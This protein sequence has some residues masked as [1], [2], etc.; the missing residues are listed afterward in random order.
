[1]NVPRATIGSEDIFW[2]L[3]LDPIHAYRIVGEI[4][5]F[6]CRISISAQGKWFLRKPIGIRW[7]K[8]RERVPQDG[9]FHR[10]RSPE[11]HQIKW[12]C[13]PPLNKWFYSVIGS[14][15]Q[16]SILSG[17]QTVGS[18]SCFGRWEV[19]DFLSSFHFQSFCLNHSYMDL[20]GTKSSE[21]VSIPAVAL[22][23][24][25]LRMA[26]F[27][28]MPIGRYGKWTETLDPLRNAFYN[29]TR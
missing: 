7:M 3:W 20:S 17:I 28:R 10:D 29:G 9:Q 14:P 5:V 18:R 12:E 23:I 22:R 21:N 2:C 24:L 27:R 25:V 13:V 11:W 8:D 1:M 4:N 26:T 6:E 16:N 15:S 19:F